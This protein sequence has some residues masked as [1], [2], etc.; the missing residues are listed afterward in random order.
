LRRGLLLSVLFHLALGG[1]A[2]VG[3]LH[4]DRDLPVDTAISVDIVTAEDHAAPPAAAP[5]AA[6]APLPE[7]QAAS[8]TPPT[9]APPSPP[10]PAAPEPQPPAPEPPRPEPPAPEPPKPQPPPEPPRPAPEPEPAREAE[11]APDVAPR[12]QPAPKKQAE[13]KPE[14]KQPPAPKKPEKK[15]AEPPK[16]PEPPKQ[17]AKAEPRK[18]EPKDE[19]PAD[20]FTALLRSVEKLDKRV[21]APEARTGKGISEQAGTPGG[22]REGQQMAQV[23]ASQLAGMISRQVTPCWRIPIGAQNAGGMRAE[24]NIVMGPDGNVRSVV[25]LDEVRLASDPVF[26]AFAE[27]AVR[28]VRACSPL[29][30]PS[31]SFHQW[32]NV[33]FNFDPSMMT[34]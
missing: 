20:D 3:L 31:E 30:L 16:R 14:P 25:P 27:S 13:E 7:R 9:P 26:R 12:P 23:S 17:V 19:A 18:A 24:L 4:F 1:L 10:K 21:K 5:Q 8:P 32:R 22:R 28:A 34:G 33:I 2:V 29:K 15:T 6:A 11:P